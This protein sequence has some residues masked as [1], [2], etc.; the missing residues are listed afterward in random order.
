[1]KEKRSLQFKIAFEGVYNQRWCVYLALFWRFSWPGY[2][3][4]IEYD[5]FGGV[6]TVRRILHFGPLSGVVNFSK[7]WRY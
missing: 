2:R 5:A 7:A 3:K 4:E 1:M 6:D